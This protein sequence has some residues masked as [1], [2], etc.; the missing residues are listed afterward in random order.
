MVARQ[1]LAELKDLAEQGHLAGDDAALGFGVAL[2]L[3]QL[4]ALVVL[5]EPN[6]GLALLG[7]EAAAQVR[8]ALAQLRQQRLVTAEHDLQHVQDLLQAEPFRDILQS[9][10]VILE[11]HEFFPG[12]A[13]VLT[14]E[15]HQ[16]SDGDVLCLGDP[17]LEEVPQRLLIL[18]SLLELEEDL[19]DVRI[20]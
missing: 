12:P 10:Y 20:D 6:P 17:V 9:A 1:P 4:V 14:G 11:V 16:F 5:A 13:P 7:H 8:P 18:D 2:G 19:A 3:L 15:A